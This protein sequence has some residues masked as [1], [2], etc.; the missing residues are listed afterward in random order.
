MGEGSA[1]FLMEVGGWGNGE[2]AGERR[3]DKRC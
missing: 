3:G 1:V 2:I